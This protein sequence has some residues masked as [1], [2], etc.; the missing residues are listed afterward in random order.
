MPPAIVQQGPQQRVNVHV[1]QLPINVD[2]DNARALAAIRLAI[3]ANFTEAHKGRSAEQSKLVSDTDAQHCLFYVQTA[4]RNGT[5]SDAPAITLALRGIPFTGS[6]GGDNVEGT[7]NDIVEKIGV[8]GED[9]FAFDYYL[10]G[11]DP[12]QIVRTG[13]TEE[14]LK[15]VALKDGFSQLDPSLTPLHAIPIDQ[16]TAYVMTAADIVAHPERYTSDGM[17]FAQTLAEAR[18]RHPVAED[19]RVT[20]SCL[21]NDGTQGLHACHNV[22]ARDTAELILRGEAAPYNKQLYSKERVAATEPM[23]TAESA[24]NG[25]GRLQAYQ[26]GCSRN[27]IH[28]C[29][30]LAN[31]YDDSARGVSGLRNA[32][33][34]YKI[35]CNARYLDSCELFKKK[36]D[37]YQSIAEFKAANAEVNQV[38]EREYRCGGV[39]KEQIEKNRTM[40]AALRDAENADLEKFDALMQEVSHFHQ[41]LLETTRSC[42][43]N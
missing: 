19:A 28:A 43:G 41:S 29:Y 42:K 17:T 21:D 5:I 2:T 8:A 15:S 3:C 23:V 22:A 33:K 36:N 39:S 4:V 11:L 1:V 16:S 26:A 35:A 9:S 20:K 37:L 31:L 6:K 13:F 27:N 14:E 30:R 32:L 40:I 12:K 34:P 38:F 10:T 7:M 24:T 18:T 25:V